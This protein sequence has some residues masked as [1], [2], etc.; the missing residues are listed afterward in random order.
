M[1]LCDGEQ[2]E[3]MKGTSTVPRQESLP[4][5]GPSPL[6]ANQRSRSSQ[7]HLMNSDDMALRTM[8]EGMLSHRGRICVWGVCVCVC[9]IEGERD[10]ERQREKIQISYTNKCKQDPQPNPNHA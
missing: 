5:T 6:Q 2:R 3:G 10:V 4:V 8:S 9:V 7:V 1:G